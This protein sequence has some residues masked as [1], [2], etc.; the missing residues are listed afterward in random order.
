[1]FGKSLFDKLVYESDRRTYTRGS[2]PDRPGNNNNS[3]DGSWRKSAAPLVSG[4]G[5]SSGSVGVQSDDG[6]ESS[7]DLEA[8]VEEIIDDKLDDK[9]LSRMLTYFPFLSEHLVQPEEKEEV[10]PS[11]RKKVKFTSSMNVDQ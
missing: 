11:Q 4:L 3:D 8:I 5:K 7:D 9:L 6:S 2:A 10:P 1:M